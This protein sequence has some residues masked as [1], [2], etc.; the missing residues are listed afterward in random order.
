[1]WVDVAARREGGPRF[2]APARGW[3]EV[4]HVVRNVWDQYSIH[5]TVFA[6]WEKMH[7]PSPVEPNAV[8]FSILRR[9]NFTTSSSE[10]EGLVLGEK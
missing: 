10:A 5:S 7:A 1:M 8:S 4:S 9:K 3:T 2:R 6:V